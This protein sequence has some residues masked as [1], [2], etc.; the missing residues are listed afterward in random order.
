MKNSKFSYLSAILLLSSGI[1]GCGN[2]VY[3]FSY[4]PINAQYSQQ[5]DNIRL[6]MTKAE[7]RQL[8]PNLVT[9]GQTTVG[10]QIIEAL[11][12]QHNY[13]AGVGGRLV[14][15]RLWFYFQNDRLVK[16]GQPNDW[17]Q[18]PDVIIEKRLR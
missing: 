13:W 2:D 3:S 17:P 18:N 10:G 6:G 1:S 8:I 11:E 7:V 4:T 15:D 14:N 9:R 12:L 16:W 5:L